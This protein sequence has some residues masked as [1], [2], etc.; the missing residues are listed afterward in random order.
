MHVLGDQP[1][2]LQDPDALVHVLKTKL[3]WFVAA[4]AVMLVL[5]I[6]VDLFG[7]RAKAGAAEPR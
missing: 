3:L 7:R 5:Y 4:A 1:R 6:V 2:L